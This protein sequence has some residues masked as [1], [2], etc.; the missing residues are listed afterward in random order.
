MQVLRSVVGR[1]ML[2]N[3]GLPV[4]GV[5]EFDRGV[6]RCFMPRPGSVGASHYGFCELFTLLGPKRPRRQVGENEPLVDS[7]S[8]PTCVSNSLFWALKCRETSRTFPILSQAGVSP[9]GEPAPGGWN[10]AF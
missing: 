5:V 10:R 7:S 4:C 1:E 9:K 3:G 2:R 8:E 6:N